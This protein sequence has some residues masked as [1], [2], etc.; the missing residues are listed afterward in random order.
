MARRGIRI[1]FNQYS[2]QMTFNTVADPGLTAIN[3]ISVPL[4]PRPR[5]DGLQIS[6]AIRLRQS[7]TAAQLPRGKAWQ[8]VRFLRVCTETFH[9]GRHDK[10]RVKNA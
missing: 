3:D 10:M 8:P 1:G 2:Q 9:G 6:A 4:R 5:P 7:N